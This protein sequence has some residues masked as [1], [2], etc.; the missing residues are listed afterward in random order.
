MKKIV[1]YLTNLWYSLI[2]IE[3]VEEVEHMMPEMVMQGIIEKSNTLEQGNSPK[4]KDYKLLRKVLDFL[5]W[6]ELK[7]KSKN[8]DYSKYIEKNRDI[9][10]GKPI[11]K[12]TR[13]EPITVWNYFMSIEKTDNINM[14]I[15]MK[16]IKEDYPA[17]DD[18][19]ILVSF[20]YCIKTNS[21]KQL[22]R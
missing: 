14:D 9:C 21:F 18:D 4:K 15:I 16:K 10:N 19:K 13:I 12:G 8:F 7:S 22:L 11:V 2:R 1:E 3:E 6:N 20:L 17:L 5:A